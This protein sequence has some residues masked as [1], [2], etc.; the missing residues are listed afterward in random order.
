MEFIPKISGYL[1]KNLYFVVSA[2]AICSLILCSIWTERN[3]FFYKMERHDR[4]VGFLWYLRNSKSILYIGS[5][6]LMLW[7]WKRSI[8]VTLNVVPFSTEECPLCWLVSHWRCHSVFEYRYL[9]GS[10]WW[11]WL[12]RKRINKYWTAFQHIFVI[13]G[14][15]IVSELQS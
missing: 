8:S 2:I 3:C 10:L 1:W 4:Y 12:H 13:C 9:A 11:Y 14:S 7:D 6:I 5:D 15:H